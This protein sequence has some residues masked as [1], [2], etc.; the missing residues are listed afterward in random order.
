MTYRFKRMFILIENFI[1]LGPL[2]LLSES[3]LK[4]VGSPTMAAQSLAH[5]YLS[6]STT[7]TWSYPNDHPR[8]FPHSGKFYKY[9]CGMN[10]W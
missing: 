4:D 1:N 10:N 9:H 7:Y 3:L 5:G 8:D 2:Q 6:E